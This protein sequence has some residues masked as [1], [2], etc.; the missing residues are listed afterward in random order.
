MNTVNG[1]MN[2]ASILSHLNVVA[3]ESS[4]E[5]AVNLFNILDEKIKSG[6]NNDHDDDYDEGDGDLY[7]DVVSQVSVVNLSLVKGCI[8]CLASLAEAIFTCA[9]EN[10]HIDGMVIALTTTHNNLL[11]DILTRIYSTLLVSVERAIHDLTEVTLSAMKT[12]FAADARTVLTSST[13]ISSYISLKTSIINKQSI[14]MQR[15]EWDVH[16]IRQVCM[17]I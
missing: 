16:A 14:S 12:I 5:A 10:D 15:A 7:G 9:V 8:I 1:N 3:V 17:L 11:S 13:S 6:L 2:I 4:Q